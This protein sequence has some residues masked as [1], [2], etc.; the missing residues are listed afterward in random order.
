MTRLPGDPPAADSDI[1]KSLGLEALCE[2]L[3]LGAGYSILDLSVARGINIDF[4]ARFS[5]RI[6]FADLHSSM[7][8]AALP[9]EGQEMQYWERL[10]G[11]PEA[12]R[13]DVVLSWDLFN[14]LEQSLLAGLAEYLIRFCRPGTLLFAL[15]LDR[16]QMPTAP[17]VF[18]IVDQQ[19]LRYENRNPDA[20]P[21]PRHQP[22]DVQRIMKGFRISSS[23]RL[24]NGV[25]EYLFEYNPGR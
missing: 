19:H 6:H 15:I 21:C 14:Y 7:A 2:Q 17:T 13:F 4:W 1:Y 20:R 3:E 22:R 10:L 25:Q 16:H 23:F 24:R 5:P 18:K 8:G 9:A 11:L 12:T